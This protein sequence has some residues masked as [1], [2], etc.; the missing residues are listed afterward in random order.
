MFR[1]FPVKIDNTDTAAVPVALA[2][3]S[4]RRRE[5][6]LINWITHMDGPWWAAGAALPCRVAKRFESWPRAVLFCYIKATALSP[7]HAPTP[8]VSID[9]CRAGYRVGR[10]LWQLQ[11][12]QRPSCQPSRSILRGRPSRFERWSFVFA[13]S[14][15]APILSVT[16][17]RKRWRRDL[18]MSRWIH[19]STFPDE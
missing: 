4:F 7:Q 2:S 12:N 18:C 16:D 13:G 11:S 5:S 19:G 1:F 10:L 9:L 17:G 14:V 6:I 15:H 3:A 8:A